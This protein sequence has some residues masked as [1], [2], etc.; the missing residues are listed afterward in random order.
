MNV[1]KQ[2]QNV[3]EGLQTIVVLHGACGASSTPYGGVHHIL[4]PLNSGTLWKRYRKLTGHGIA[5]G[6]LHCVVVHYGV[7]QFI[8]ESRNFAEALRTTGTLQNYYGSLRRIAVQVVHAAAECI[9]H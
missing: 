8:A 5:C 1:A 3:V 2:L 4:S 6:P 7:L 9:T